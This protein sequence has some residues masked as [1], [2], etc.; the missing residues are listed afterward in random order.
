MDEFVII[1]FGVVAAGV[2]CAYIFNRHKKTGQEQVPLSSENMPRESLTRV[3]PVGMLIAKTGMHRGVVFAVEPAGVRIGR[4]KSKNKI[5]IDS[6]IVSREHAWIG[7][8]DGKVVVRDL[9]SRNG[10]YV[11]SLEEPRIQSTVL[12]DGDV[13]FIGK[14]GAESFKY[15]AG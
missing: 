4:D 2:L 14:D 6:E 13:I 15:K 1:S 5:I 12:K 8:E 10:T 9:G 7:L 11:N 3:L